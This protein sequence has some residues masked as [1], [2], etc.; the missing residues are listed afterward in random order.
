MNGRWQVG[1]EI[2]LLAYQ[3][4]SSSLMRLQNDSG[5]RLAIISCPFTL[6][7]TSS[8]FLR[9]LVPWITSFIL[10]LANVSS[11]QALCN[12]TTQAVSEAPT[13]VLPIRNITIQNVTRR[14]VALSIGTP[15]QDIGFEVA[16]CVCRHVLVLFLKY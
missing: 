10:L 1:S 9:M 16:P 7:N 11:A 5:A 13:I 12:P 4:C 8:E 15:S 14:A 6:M 3:L 2:V